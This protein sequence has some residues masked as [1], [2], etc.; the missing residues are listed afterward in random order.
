M[1]KTKKPRTLAVGWMDRKRYSTWAKGRIVLT[2]I[3]F[4]NKRDC[5]KPIKVRIVE[6]K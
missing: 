2:Q 6:D 1:K 4:K 3:I 5:I